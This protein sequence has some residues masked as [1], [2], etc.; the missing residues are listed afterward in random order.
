MVASINNQ[1]TP[2]QL[3]AEIEKL[4]ADIKNNPTHTSS[5]EMQIMQL[6]TELTGDKLAD[7]SNQKKELEEKQK[8]DPQNADEYDAEIAAI[9]TQICELEEGQKS[10]PL[11][12]SNNPS[13]INSMNQK[14]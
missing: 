10:L 4:M 11:P 13:I 8:S 6:K 2:D 5:D 1:P 12:N 9:Q 3:Q 7:L 14:C